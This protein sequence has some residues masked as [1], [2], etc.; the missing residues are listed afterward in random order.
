MNIEKIKYFIDLVECRNFTETAKKNHVS[1]TTISQ[2]MAS[3]EREFDNKLFDRKQIPIQP[4]PAGWIFYKEALIIYKQFQSMKQKME[5]HRE[6]TTELLSIVYASPVDVKI[7]N[8]I[9]PDFLRQNR[10]V[11]VEISREK[12]GEISMALKRGIYDLAVCFDSEFEGQ[13]GIETGTL[14]QGR[15]CAVVG[16]DHPLYD[17]EELD[18]ENLYSH[19][20]V[21]LNPKIIGLSYDLMVEHVHRDGYKPDIVRYTDDVES[22]LFY[23][24]NE[25]LIGFFPEHYELGEYG[26]RVRKI[27]IA[28]TRHLYQIQMA[29][30]SDNSNPALKKLLRYKNLT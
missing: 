17:T 5:A 3:L 11:K 26:T 7:L 13:E 16:R 25:Q 2:H 4:T 23:I 27:P 24:I 18:N 12:L 30:I 9:M 19:P 8:E 15:Y 14:T 29:W 20:L 28:S 1:Q 6:N 22:E 21:M 10:R